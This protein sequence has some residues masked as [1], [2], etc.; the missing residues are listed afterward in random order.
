M[1]SFSLALEYMLPHEGVESNHPNDHGGRTKYG[2]TQRSLDMFNHARPG[3]GLP[4]DVYAVTLAQ[5]QIFYSHA[6]YWQ[7]DGVKDQRIASKLF[8]MSVNMGGH[9]ALKLAQ[10]ILG[11]TVDGLYGPATEAA[12]NAQDPIILLAGLCVAAATFYR[13]LAA[14]D[15]SQE[16]FLKGWLARAHSVPPVTV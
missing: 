14:K 3:F 12:I 1:A 16:V 4:T 8:D 11:V 13:G 15:P 9:Q 5:A 2:I 7:F 10:P 6:G